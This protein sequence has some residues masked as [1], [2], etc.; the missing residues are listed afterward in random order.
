MPQNVISDAPQ[1]QKETLWYTSFADKAQTV[2]LLFML[3]TCNFSGLRIYVCDTP[4]WSR[5]PNPK[6]WLSPNSFKRLRH[7]SIIFSHLLRLM[8]YRTSERSQ[9]KCY[10]GLFLLSIFPQY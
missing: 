9:H 4:W 3:L 7:L 6:G 2:S 10:S 8:F 1:T 5:H